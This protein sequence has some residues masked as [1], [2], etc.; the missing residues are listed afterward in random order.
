MEKKTLISMKKEI[1]L[2]NKKVKYT[3]R[4]SKRAGR[5][6]LAVY[7]GGGFVVTIPHRMGL[8]KAEDFILQKAEWVLKKIKIMRR[9]KP[10]GIF[11]RQ[12]KREYLK[13]KYEALKMAEN[14]VVEFNKFY[15]FQYNKISI[16]NQK[17][18]WGSCSE[19]GNLNY[20]YKIILLPE[21]Y[22]DYI[23]VHEL[24]HLK[25]LNHSRKFWDLVEKTIP[26]YRERVKELKKL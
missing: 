14:K 9:K 21:K 20:N 12:S 1:T 24:C 16:R 22:A 17:T 13:L 8:A 4:Q 23:I 25:E 11:T 6:R 26:D 5:M 10:N 18:R 15:N 19:K 3:I 7:S 2:K